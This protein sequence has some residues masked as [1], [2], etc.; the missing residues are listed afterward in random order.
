VRSF[1]HHPPLVAVD[2]GNMQRLPDGHF[3]VG[4]GHQ[5]WYTEYSARGRV[6][7]DARFGRDDNS[8]RA[9][10]FP[11]V[12]RPTTGPALVV[13]GDTAYVSWNG[14]T[15]VARWRLLAGMANDDLSVVR[16]VPKRTFETRFAIPNGARYV[17]VEALGADG[18]ILR[19]SATAGHR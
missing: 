11:W 14:S 7:L 3:L 12:G 4:W 10:R 5:P 15:Q 8:Y 13:R 9:Y 1:V 2:Q 16:T 17:A 19:V 6:V 18:G